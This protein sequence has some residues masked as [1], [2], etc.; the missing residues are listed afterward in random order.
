MGYDQSGA[1]S[2]PESGYNP[3]Q[4]PHLNEVDYAEG[5]YRDPHSK[6]SKLGGKVESA[7]GTIVGSDSLRAKGMQK[8]RFVCF[9][10]C[11]MSPGLRLFFP[12][13]HS[14]ARSLN[15]QSD[16]LAQAESLEREA[17]MHRD[18]TV[19]GSAGYF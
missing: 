6:P 4:Q 1:N 7:I 3:S 13:A 9:A 2:G 19:G 17:Q 11:R 10:P 15:M 12:R 14:E 16:E 8:E 18:R 5:G